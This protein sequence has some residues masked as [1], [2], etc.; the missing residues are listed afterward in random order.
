MIARASII[1]LLLTFAAPA[2]VL[3]QPAPTASIQDAAWLTGHWVGEGLGGELDEAFSA[4]LGGQMAGHLRL[5]RDGKP[6]FYEMMLIE[7]HQGALRFRVKHF[8]PDF[9][10]WEEKDR[11]L[12]FPFVSA[13]PGELV[14]RSLAFRKDGPD[15]MVI[16]LRMR[17]D[18]GEAADQV[19]RL[20]RAGP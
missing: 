12:D 8:D 9:T 19:M 7:E 15:R 5:S 11:S 2:A 6:V 4:P 20:R 10:G 1:I 16:T 13:A 3:A 14:F 18:N 17:Q